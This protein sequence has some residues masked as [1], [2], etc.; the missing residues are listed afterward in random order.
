MASKKSLVQHFA[1]VPM[2]VPCTRGE[3]RTLAKLASET[4][5]AAGTVLTEEGKPG[6]EFVIVLSG[7][8][9]ARRNGRKVATFTAGDYFGEIALLDLGPRTATITAD[10]DMQLAV[11]GPAAFGQMLEDVPTLA[12]KIMRGL[13]RRIREMDTRQI[14]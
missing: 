11:V 12:H 3:L 13:A 2:F 5:V 14:V 8:A 4:A 1:Q 9:T 7:D 10:T 6:Q